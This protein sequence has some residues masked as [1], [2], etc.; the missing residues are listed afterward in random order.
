[1]KKEICK[2]LKGDAKKKCF[3]K[4]AAKRAV[5]KDSL[6]RDRTRKRD[7]ITKAR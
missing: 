5:K 7:S 4:E 2:G 3:Q 6:M 1:M